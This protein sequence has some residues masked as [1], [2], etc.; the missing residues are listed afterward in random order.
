[1]SSPHA[2][3]AGENSVRI[4]VRDETATYAY[5]DLFHVKLRV[6]AWIPGEDEPYV[7]NLERAGVRAPDLEVI[8]ARLL[9]DFERHAL[10]YLLR[11]DFPRRWVEHRSRARTRVIPFPGAS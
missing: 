8:R 6:S 1:M 7:R 9:A 3:F 5:A 10:P 4:E 2:A 11:P